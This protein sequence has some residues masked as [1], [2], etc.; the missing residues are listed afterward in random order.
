MNLQI[1]VNVAVGGMLGEKMGEYR[2]NNPIGE[3][4]WRQKPEIFEYEKQKKIRFTGENGFLNTAQR[5]P[6]FSCLPGKKATNT[7]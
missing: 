5:P 4:K 2:V 6:S 1:F 7:N 3:G